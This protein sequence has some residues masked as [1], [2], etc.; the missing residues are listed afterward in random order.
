MSKPAQDLT[1]RDFVKSMAAGLA[2]AATAGRGA[3]VLAGEADKARVRN[4][5]VLS[6]IHIGYKDDEVDG[7]EWF[8]RAMDELNANQVPI[9]YA[10]ALGDLV[11]RADAASYKTYLDI[12]QKSKISPWFEIAGNHDWSGNETKHFEASVRSIKPHAH[13]DGNV[14]WFFISDE[15]AGTR[16]FI[17]DATIDWLRN[18]LEQHKDDI[19]IVCTHQ[20]VADTVRTSTN[21]DRIIHPKEKIAKVLADFHVD[22]WMFGHEHHRPYSK[23]EILRKNG[24]TFLN[25]A[26]LSHAY[27]TK[28]SQSYVLRFEQGA[29]QILARRRVH[30]VQDFV[31]DYDLAIPLDREIR[32]GAAVASEK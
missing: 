31:K 9:D 21:V 32:L 8:S 23:E 27:K 11:H 19:K 26:S 10:V 2:I 5:L 22:L 25:V 29:K 14:A 16:G 3:L 20:L 7:A 12:R 15:D 4:V 17:S 24:T 18:G 1:R 6:D 13:V 28:E 30:D